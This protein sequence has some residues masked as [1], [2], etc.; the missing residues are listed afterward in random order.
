MRH[1]DKTRTLGRT[2]R[3]RT[4]LLRGLAIALITKGKIKTTTAKAKELRPL[5]ERLV[6]YGKKNT[7]ASRRQAATALGEPKALVLKK[8]FEEIAPQY[9]ERSG[10]YT[11]IVKAGRTEAGR[12]ESII[13]FVA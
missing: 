10:G 2:R 9:Q 4:A 12:D 13:E 3:G 6:T 8:L 11:R 7:L 1:A 5:A